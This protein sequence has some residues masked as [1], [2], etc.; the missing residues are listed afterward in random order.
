VFDKFMELLIFAKPVTYNYYC[1]RM[2]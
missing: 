1:V 2:L